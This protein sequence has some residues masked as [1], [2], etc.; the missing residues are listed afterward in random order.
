VNN[1]IRIIK[2]IRLVKM[3][4]LGFDHFQFI[5]KDLEESVEYFKKMGFKL[6]RRTEHHEG[7]AEFQIGPDGPIMEIHTSGRNENPGHDHFAVLVEDLDTAIKEL[8]DKGI[9][10]EGPR[11]VPATGRILANFRDNDGFRWQFISPKKD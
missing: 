3:K 4:I 7:S 6:V 9:K 1:L 10:V 8:R 2:I 11:V 5:V